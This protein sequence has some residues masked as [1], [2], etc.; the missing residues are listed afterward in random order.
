MIISSS[1]RRKIDSA[2]PVSSKLIELDKFVN[3]FQRILTTSREPGSSFLNNSIN[4]MP[5]PKALEKTGMAA[6][7]KV[8]I[9][10]PG[11]GSS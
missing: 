3:F 1:T 7:G 8:T 6:I 9:E 2:K 11:R 4:P 5:A 10:A